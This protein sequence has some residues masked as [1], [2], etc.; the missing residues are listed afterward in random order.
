MVRLY[1]LCTSLLTSGVLTGG[2]TL[3]ALGVPEKKKR[4]VWILTLSSDYFS[5]VLPLDYLT[6][7]SCKQK[8][9]ECFIK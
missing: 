6:S 5:M 8:Y 7:G 1:M 9:V 4:N 2:D 3:A